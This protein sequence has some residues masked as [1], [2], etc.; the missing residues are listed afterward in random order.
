VG[1]EINQNKTNIKA[2]TE[3]ED[4]IERLDIDA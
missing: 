3:I 1:N 4:C 2:H